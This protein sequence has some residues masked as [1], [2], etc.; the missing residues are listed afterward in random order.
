MRKKLS[1]EDL[2]HDIINFIKYA[3]SI[4]DENLKTVPFSKGL[5]RTD[6]LDDFKKVVLFLQK[7]INEEEGS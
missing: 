7:F 5:Q 2:K 4:R 1:I 3:N 6:L